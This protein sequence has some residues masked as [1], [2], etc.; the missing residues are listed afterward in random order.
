MKFT[1]ENGEHVKAGQPYAEVEVMKMYMP[2]LAGE[3]GIVQLIKQPGA[4]LEAGDI[5]G[6]L[7]LDDPS[8]VKHAQPFLSQLPD[9]GRP[10]VVGTKPAQRFVLLHNILR[11]ILQGFDNQFIMNETLKDLIEVLRDPELPYS[12]W[13]AQFSALHARM[14]Q[15]L[16][17]LFG[18]I[19]ERAK[20]RKA[21]FPAKNLQKA[22]QKL[23][24]KSVV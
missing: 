10:Q 24:R 14:P 23:D 6:I 11:N 21:E 2:L 7:A 17:S 1:V 12:E 9:L 20:A 13:N 3:D 15:K 4:T 19:V 16:D 8:R 5:I 22:L 18:Q